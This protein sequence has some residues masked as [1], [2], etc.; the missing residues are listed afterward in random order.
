MA[1][2]E[3]FSSV[4]SSTAANTATVFKGILHSP[5]QPSVVNI[6]AENVVIQ[7]GTGNIAPGR[8]MS[9][10][11]TQTGKNARAE[12]TTSTKPAQKRGSPKMQALSLGSRFLIIF[13]TIVNAT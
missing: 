7:T 6:Q 10:S 8:D 3:K 2:D 11:T 13:W 12:Q 1:D 4:L 5:F 9:N